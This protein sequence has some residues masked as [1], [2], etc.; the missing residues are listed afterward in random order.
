[1]EEYQYTKT[2]LQKLLTS[3]IGQKKFLFLKLKAL[4]CGDM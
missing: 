1:M 2:F 4:F 3:Q